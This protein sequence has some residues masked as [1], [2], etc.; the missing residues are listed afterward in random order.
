[1][2]A[3]NEDLARRFFVEADRGRM[4]VE[5]CDEV[6]VRLRMEG[7]TPATSWVSRPAASGSRKARHSCVIVGARSPSSGVLL[8]SWDLMQ[9]I[10]GCPRQTGPGES[11]CPLR[12]EQVPRRSQR[13]TDLSQASDRS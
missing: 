11:R 8:T 9:Q 2:S 4:P 10:G 5:L 6:A 1:M 7:T 3:A 13:P 12:P